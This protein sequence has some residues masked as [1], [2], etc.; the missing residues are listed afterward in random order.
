RGF[1]GGLI[2]RFLLQRFQNRRADFVERGLCGLRRFAGFRETCAD[3]VLCFKFVG[4]L[5]DVLNRVFVGRLGFGA[6][7]R[8]VLQRFLQIL[9]IVAGFVDVLLLLL[10][11]LIIVFVLLLLGDGAGTDARQR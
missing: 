6:A 10:N 3:F 9:H 1:R 11:L 4:E 5:L 7:G 8:R 2:L